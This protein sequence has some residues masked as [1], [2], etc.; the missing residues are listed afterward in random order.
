MASFRNTGP[1]APPV[2]RLA[3]VFDVVWK[4]QPRMCPLLPDRPRRR[5]EVRIRERAYRGG[6]DSRR[7][8]RGVE[9]GRA[10][11]RTEAE[12]GAF[13]SSETRMYCREA[14]SIVTWSASNRAWTPKTLPVRRWQARQWQIETRTGSPS[15]G[16][17]SCSQLHAGCRVP[18][19]R[20]RRQ[21]R[22]SGH[23]RTLAQTGCLTPGMA[24]R[25][26]SVPRGDAHDDTRAVGRS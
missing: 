8:L 24:L 6:H 16:S 17:G 2:L 18:T 15:T 11:V 5:R 4:P 1:G 19:R 9:D 10:A 20:D 25:L 12:E 26:F 7:G 21:G 14:P 3:Q 22:L 23:S 13:P